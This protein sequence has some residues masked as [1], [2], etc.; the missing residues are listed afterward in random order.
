MNLVLAT[1][2]NSMNSINSIGPANSTDPYERHHPNERHHSN[3]TRR[4]RRRTNACSLVTNS[5]LITLHVLDADNLIGDPTTEDPDWVRLVQQ[6][7]V[8]VT[9]FE[10]GPHTRMVLG[11]GCNGS[12]VLVVQS[13]W[14][15]PARFV[16][17]PGPDGADFALI[18]AIDEEISTGRIGRVFIGSGDG[19]F[20]DP[21]RALVR[22]GVPVTVVS[23]PGA[24]SY[25]L[26][27]AARGNV[28]Y[29]PD[30]TRGV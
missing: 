18:E 29:V 19:R 22:E 16:R 6:F 27:R 2:I 7:Y 8:E 4:R 3:D 30:L 23:R 1:S 9:G 17:R 13:T 10:S 21:V 15:G 5:D 28:L 11:T 14:S 26:R 20:A 24:L 12:H 25:D